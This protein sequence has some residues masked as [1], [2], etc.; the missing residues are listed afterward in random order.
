MV[1]G[2]RLQP[3][4]LRC[5]SIC[6]AVARCARVDE[7]VN[8]SLNDRSIFSMLQKE[9]MSA[10][11]AEAAAAH[12]SHVPADPVPKD[13]SDDSLVQQFAASEDMEECL[14]LGPPRSWKY[15]TCGQVKSSGECTQ[16]LAARTFC[17]R[18]CGMC[19][20]HKVRR[21]FH[22]R[23]QKRHRSP[24]AT[25]HEPN[26]EDRTLPESAPFSDCRAVDFG[27]ACSSPAA[28]KFCPRTCGICSSRHRRLRE[29]VWR[30]HAG[31][32]DVTD[33]LEQALR[34][35]ASE[36][37]DWEG[38]G[39]PTDEWEESNIAPV[40]GEYPEK[41]RE[42]IY[43]SFV[44]DD[45]TSRQ[46]FRDAATV[47]LFEMGRPR[48]M[49]K[50]SQVDQ[51]SRPK[52][53]VDDRHDGFVNFA[54]KNVNENIQVV[55]VKRD[56]HG[57]WIMEVTETVQDTPPET[58]T[59]RANELPSVS[60]TAKS[61]TI[62]NILPTH[63]TMT[64]EKETSR[65][66]NTAQ[67][68]PIKEFKREIQ[69]SQAEGNVSVGAPNKHTHEEETIDVD[70][71]KK[72]KAPKVE[73]GSGFVGSS[74]RTQPNQLDRS[75]TGE[76]SPD[77]SR[78]GLRHVGDGFE[79][80]SE[81][82]VK[83]DEKHLDDLFVMGAESEE[84]KMQSAAATL[85]TEAKAEETTAKYAASVAAREAETAA[86]AAAHAASAAL[87]QLPEEI[88]PAEA[89]RKEEKTR[90]VRVASTAQV[91]ALPSTVGGLTGA[92]RFEVSVGPLT[93]VDRIH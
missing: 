40:D 19:D 66:G 64:P 49:G 25:H 18:T 38:D 10:Q 39:Q 50:Q 46:A 43:P 88:D 26:C 28:A 73:A 87:S 27:R 14:D 86:M 32:S 33:G 67:V 45:P 2:R 37:E 59:S 58:T 80:A 74:A 82:S 62:D 93:A 5:A 72:L 60:E 56:G 83:P 24:S 30:S 71:A 35:I 13:V 7:S 92:N 85:M 47:G 84:A 31:L 91:T 16:S 78:A 41:S 11:T 6:F 17:R 9:F 1:A 12:A 51:E 90:N 76:Q 70:I 22:G 44:K 69:G 34:S 54:V 15:S 55:V 23:L 52:F 42:D 8:M 61:V 57:K 79:M 89:E 3:W 63:E 4:I 21:G 53:E 77:L 29:S 68:E 81:R 20:Q 65:K 75:A 48:R 36:N